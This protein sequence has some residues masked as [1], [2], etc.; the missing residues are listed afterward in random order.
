MVGS[1]R[2]RWRAPLV[3]GDD[4]AAQLAR[5]AQIERLGSKA[6]DD[7]RVGLLSP[8]TARMI[9]RLPE[10]NQGEVL[11]AARREALAGAELTGHLV[12]L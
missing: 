12:D 8:T 11:D 9:V 3:K 6:C 5:L 7:L 10:G 4:F 2:G 1:G